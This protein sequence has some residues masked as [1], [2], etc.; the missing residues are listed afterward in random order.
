MMTPEDLDV[1]V[2]IPHYER[3]FLL[4]EALDSISEHGNDVNSI[5]V[6]DDGSSTECVRVLEKLLSQSRLSSRIE[7]VRHRRNL[8]G[9]AARNSGVERVQTQWVFNLD[10]DNLLGPG[11]IKVLHQGALDEGL[12]V[13]VPELIIYFRTQPA[14]ATHA[15]QFDLRDVELQ[16]FFLPDWIVPPAS[17]NYLFSTEGWSRIGGYPENAGPLD[18]WG[19]GLRQV[20]SGQRMR[21]V[22]G[23]LQFHRHGHSSYWR[24][25]NQ[26]EMRASVDGLIDEVF[27]TFPSTET[28]RLS[29][30]IRRGRRRLVA[31]RKGLR[32]Q[33]DL[34]PQVSGSSR[35]RLGR[36]LKGSSARKAME[37]R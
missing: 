15:W 35:T 36:T 28:H 14:H 22:A 1:S 13:A 23:A 37:S 4:S 7:L 25:G 11:L 33:P 30:V 27:S 24:D 32:L 2:V 29:R 6:V 10:S 9:G 5:V 8:G 20:T 16:D 18:T 12:E 17:G 3:A 34:F 19:F 26:D 31:S 21:A